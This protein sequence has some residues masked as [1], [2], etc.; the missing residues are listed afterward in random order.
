[1]RRIAL[2][3]LLAAVV[4]APVALSGAGVAGAQSADPCAAAK[5][6][7]QCGPGNNRRTEGGGD[8]V[9]H[10]GWPAISG[11]LWKVLD[12]S[13]RLTGGPLS[14]ELLGRHGNDRL[15]GGAG[16]DVLWG[17]WDPVGNTTRQR[18]VLSGGSGNDFLYSSHGHNR[19]RGGTGNDLVWAYYGRG[20]IDC[21]PGRDTLRVRLVNRYRARNCERVRNFCAHGSK[22]GGG[23]YK[24]GERRRP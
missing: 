12:G 3:V 6:G 5:P 23:C 10:A 8:K 20:T 7:A 2:R 1:V 21:G 15:A 17:D 24:P 18:D 9:S 11:V 14:D 4:A 16:A 13:H 22:P 19:I